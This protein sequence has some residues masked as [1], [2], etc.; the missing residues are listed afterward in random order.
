MGRHGGRPSHGRNNLCGSALAPVRKVL[1][2]HTTFCRFVEAR[3][4]GF[5]FDLSFRFVACDNCAKKPFLLS[6]KTGQNTFIS[7]RALLSLSCSLSGRSRIRHSIRLEKSAEA[8]TSRASVN[9]EAIADSGLRISELCGIP[10]AFLPIRNPQSAIRNSS[11]LLHHA[12][13]RRY[14]MPD[15]SAAR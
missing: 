6:L 2:Y 9:W 3:G 10:R 1:V 14:A 13:D 11:T 12:I 4:Q 15:D 8:I 7:K 5:Q